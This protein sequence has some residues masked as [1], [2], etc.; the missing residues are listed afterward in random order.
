MLFF[1]EVTVNF[2][3]FLKLSSYLI[4]FNSGFSDGC[5]QAIHAETFLTEFNPARNVFSVSGESLYHSLI[6]IY[7]LYYLF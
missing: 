7:L 4:D 1:F 5:W 2:D 3:Y 6:I